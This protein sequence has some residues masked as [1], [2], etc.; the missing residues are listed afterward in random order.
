[1]NRDEKQ[2]AGSINSGRGITEDNGLTMDDQA[3]GSGRAKIGREITM[4]W[5]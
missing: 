2:L 3:P 5:Y 4:K 1:M